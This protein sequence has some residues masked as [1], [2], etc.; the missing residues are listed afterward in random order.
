MTLLPGRARLVTRPLATGSLAVPNT[1][2]MVLVAV[3]ATRVTASPPS[4]TTRQLGGGPD[5]R[6]AWATARSSVREPELEGD[7]LALDVPRLQRLSEGGERDAEASAIRAE[8]R[9]PTRGI[10][11]AGWVRRGAA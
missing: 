9:R 8:L 2:G 11:A 3:A 5:R 10:P 1:I 6:L 7:V 4:V